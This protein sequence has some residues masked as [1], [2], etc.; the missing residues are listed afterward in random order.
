MRD[1]ARQLIVLCA[2][3]LVVSAVLAVATAWHTGWERW[4][5]IGADN[6]AGILRQSAT[7]LV[8]SVG[9]TLVI[10][11]GGIDLSVG[12]VMALGSVLVAL[13]LQRGAS[14][15]L[16]VAAG[17][18]GATVCGLL[19]GIVSVKG[20]I[21]SFIVTL[22][23]ML[24]AR[25][26]AFV[27]AGGE[28]IYVGSE[29]AAVKSLPL[30]LPA[31]TVL[32]GWLVLDRTR[33]GRGLYAVGGNTEA[34]RLSGLRVDALRIG[35]FAICGATAGLAAVIHWARSGT[36][37]N[38]TGEAAEL[39]AIAAVV[40]GGTSIVGGEG[41]VLGTLL[42]VLLM[43]VLRNGLVLFELSD[44]LQRL[45]IGVVIVVAVFIDRLRARG[46]AHS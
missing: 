26:V 43:S 16:A 28:T 11:S 22:G 18:G 2:A 30:A 31:V 17:V 45:V 19:N 35:A 4:P 9:M 39:D 12:S 13:A 1:T 27:I 33:F 32:A 5:F 7:F 6:L 38:L 44:E 29:S 24:V 21:P 10:I 3:L 8:L 15:P 46:R 42:G 41:H 23:M 25:A 34:A 36:G 37:S 14:V 40:I 20:R